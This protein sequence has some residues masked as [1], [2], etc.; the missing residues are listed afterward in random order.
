MTLIEGPLYIYI[1]NKLLNKSTYGEGQKKNDSHSK[2][3]IYHES[4]SGGG[5]GNYRGKKRKGQPCHTN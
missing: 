4:L 3:K 1:L 5:G 2:I